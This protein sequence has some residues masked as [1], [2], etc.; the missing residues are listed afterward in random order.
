MTPQEKKLTLEIINAYQNMI[1]YY[2]SKINELYG[3][4]EDKCCFEKKIKHKF[5]IKRT[6]CQRNKKT[7]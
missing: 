1:E 7:Y 6:T 3:K 4:M 5:K 2:Q